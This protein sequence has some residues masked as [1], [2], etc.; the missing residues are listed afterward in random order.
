MRSSEKR[1]EVLQTSHRLDVPSSGFQNA[2]LVSSVRTRER[3]AYGLSAQVAGVYL[4]MSL[5]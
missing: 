4:E 5:K 1:V 2:E 3:L